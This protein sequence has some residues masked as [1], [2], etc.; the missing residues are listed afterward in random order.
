MF[1]RSILRHFLA[2]SLFSRKNRY[3]HVHFCE[4]HSHIKLRTRI[5][6]KKRGLRTL[7]TQNPRFLRLFQATTFQNPVFLQSFW[8]DLVSPRPAWIAAWAAF[9]LEMPAK[10]EV[11]ETWA[12]KNMQKRR[13]FAP[14]KHQNL[15]FYTIFLLLSV[16]SMDFSWFICLLK[17]LPGPPPSGTRK[18]LCSYETCNSQEAFFAR[19]TKSSF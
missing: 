13:G 3:F 7:P 6:R 17:W 4:M 8:L 16:D 14:G 11:L 19:H 5:H 15:S 1:S 2:V 12:G 18:W 10:N 9:F